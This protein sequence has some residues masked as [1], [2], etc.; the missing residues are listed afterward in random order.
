MFRP[1]YIKKM[2]IREA[3]NYDHPSSINIIMSN[4]NMK[5]D[6]NQENLPQS[7][8]DIDIIDPDMLT[9]EMAQA[10][11]ENGDYALLMRLYERGC[12]M[13]TEVALISIQHRNRSFNKNE[14]NESDR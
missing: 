7:T 5:S 12:P 6:P 3:Y 4:S 14:T 9:E 13:S 2:K 10:A 11:Y 1:H 8:N